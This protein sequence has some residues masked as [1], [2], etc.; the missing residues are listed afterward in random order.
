MSPPPPQAVKMNTITVA[1]E[2]VKVQLIG[3]V[4]SA[5]DSGFELIAEA[6]AAKM[7]GAMK[8]AVKAAQ[9]VAAAAAADRDKKEAAAAVQVADIAGL[10]AQILGM[11]PCHDYLSS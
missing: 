10:R 3:V 8:E 6:A 4:R 1:I 2:D 7:A 11:S 9:E 5:L